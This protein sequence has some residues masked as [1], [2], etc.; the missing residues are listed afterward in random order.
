[1]LKA[2]QK[3]NLKQHVKGMSKEVDELEEQIDKLKVN[4]D[5]DKAQIYAEQGSAAGLLDHDVSV[6]KA[7]IVNSLDDNFKGL[8]NELTQVEKDDIEIHKT[9]LQMEKEKEINSAAAEIEEEV[10]KSH[11]SREIEEKKNDLR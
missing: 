4:M 2:R 3:K 1:M 9:Q 7:R 6:K 8:D 5:T 10:I 11:K